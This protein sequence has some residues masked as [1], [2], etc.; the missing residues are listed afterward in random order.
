V[1]TNINGHFMRYFHTGT[2]RTCDQRKSK[3]V[4]PANSAFYPSG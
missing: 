1:T 3:R 2:K 4:R